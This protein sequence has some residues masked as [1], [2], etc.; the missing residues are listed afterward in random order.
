MHELILAAASGALP[1][2]AVAG[3]ERRAHMRRVADLLGAWADRSGLD[4]DDVV[5]W[6]AMGNLHDALRD[7]DP[8]TLRPRVPPTL[9]SLPGELLHG[10][11]T[12]ER[13]RVEGVDDG[14]LLKA[15]AFHTLGDPDFDVSGRALYVADFLD[16]ARAFLTDWRA[17]LRDRMPEALD[18]VVREIARARIGN[19]LERGSTVHRRTMDFWNALVAER[20]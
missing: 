1:S 6:R 20:S 19:L 2:W 17:G 13:L 7:A 4:R 3:E 5:R 12:A 15:I 18:E 16:P 14:S 9:R 10:P 8:E 11:A